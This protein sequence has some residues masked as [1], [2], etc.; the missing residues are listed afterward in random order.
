MSDLGLTLAWFAVQVTLVLV[1]ALA[2]HAL[3]SRRGPASGAWVASVGLGLAV[4]VGLAVAGPAGPDAGAAEA[5]R[6]A[7]GLR[8]ARGPGRPAGT[9]QG[10]RT[11]RRTT[12][13]AD[14]REAPGRVGRFDRR[15]PSRRRVPA[16]GKLPGAVAA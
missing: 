15:R 1:P 13:V 5:P 16:L 6:R 10:G 11:R 4:A 8:R 9:T 7:A 14:A 2:L 3:A 12:A